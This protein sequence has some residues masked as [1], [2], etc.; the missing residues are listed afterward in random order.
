MVDSSKAPPEVA[1]GYSQA[2]LKIL[3]ITLNPL[4]QLRSLYESQPRPFLHILSS[5]NNIL[6]SARSEIYK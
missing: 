4:S 1:D 6:S 2:K 5:H 3:L